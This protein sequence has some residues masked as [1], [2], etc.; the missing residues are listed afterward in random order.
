MTFR[1]RLSPA[2]Y[3][4]GFGALSGLAYPQFNL[5][6]AIFVS[7]AGL[8]WLAQ[9]RGLRASAILGLIAGAGFYTAQIYWISQYLGPVPLI[10]LSLLQAIIFCLGFVAT[11]VAW[12]MFPAV[13]DETA[14]G[15]RAIAKRLGFAAVIASI[16]VAR[17]WLS[18]HWPYG[19]FPWSR[20]AMSQ[21]QSPLADYAFLG[22]ISAISFAVAF[23]SVSGLLAAQTIRAKNLRFA[24]P[25]LAAIAVAFAV[26]L[27]FTPPINAE[28]GTLTIAAVQGNANAGLFANS[29]P[30]SIFKKHLAA[31]SL[32]TEKP[33]GQRP[34]VVI[35]PENAVD[36]NPLGNANAAIELNDFVSRLDRP[37]ILGT[38]TQTGDQL[39]NSS[40]LW[41]PSVGLVDQYDKKRPVPFAEYV[42]NRDFWARLAPDLIGLIWHDYAFGTRDGI[43][44]VAGTK[45]GV[46]ICFEIAVDELNR[47]L[48]AQGA[49]LIVSQTNNADFG[50]SAETF[51]QAELA[52]LRAIETGRAVVNDSTVGV[53]AVFLPNGETLAQI[54]PFEPGYLQTTVPLRTSLTPAFFTAP[55]V[56]LF[57]AIISFAAICG[58]A[59]RAMRLRLA[60]TV[61]RTESGGE[62]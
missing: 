4:L 62:Q 39:F 52:R 16:W 56:E 22:G 31:S 55:Y 20:L 61:R 45:L 2:L 49:T 40:L 51:Q 43:F 38:I 9:G 29:I 34:D 59:I 11:T 32:L 33:A 24:L 12:R 17:E 53:T 18:T 15:M 37:L 30:G 21:G 36:A 10:A 60:R 8:T 7:V 47:D 6:P 42:P 44:E 46:N 19:G 54:E 27:S 48:V 5:W 14:T 13:L 58:Y 25:Q 26:P 1:T 50:R 41:Q 57:S 28:Q 35:W 23:I 3:A